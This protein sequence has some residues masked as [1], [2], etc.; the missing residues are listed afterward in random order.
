MQLLIEQNLDRLQ[1]LSHN[2]LLS[3]SSHQDKLDSAHR[4]VVSIL[5]ALQGVESSTTRIQST[6]LS[7]TSWSWWPHILCPAASLFLGS[8]RLSPSTA[9][10]LL[11]LGLGTIFPSLSFCVAVLTIERRNCWLDYFGRPSHPGGHIDAIHS[12]SATDHLQ[13]HVQRYNANDSR[14]L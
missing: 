5:G 3:H 9:R 8:Y 2:V 12:H 6:F 7:G 11:L 14:S 4:S 10:N 1:Q 13:D